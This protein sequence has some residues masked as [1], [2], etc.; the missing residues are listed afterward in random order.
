MFKC[1]AEADLDCIKGQQISNRGNGY[2][3]DINWMI[4]RFE[5]GVAISKFDGFWIEDNFSTH[6]DRTG[7]LTQDHGTNPF[8]TSSAIGPD[9]T[10]ND[11]TAV[12]LRFRYNWSDVIQASRL[13]LNTLMDLVRTRA[14]S[15]ARLKVRNVITILALAT[16]YL[17]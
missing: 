11:E 12:A 9:F 6:S 4:K 14:T 16:V 15:A 3:F 10:N 13:N 5:L 7:G 1:A 2:F 8:P 17:G